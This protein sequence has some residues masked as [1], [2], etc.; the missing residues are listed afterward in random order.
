MGRPA[1]RYEAGQTLYDFAELTNSGDDTTFSA[2]FAP[3]SKVSGFEP[4]FGGYGLLTGAGITPGSSNDEVD[5]AALTVFAPGMTGAN[6]AGVVAVSAATGV[7][8]TRAVSTDT[9][10]INSITVDSTGTVVAVTGTDGT[11]FSETRGAAGG[12]PLIP[13]GSVE[14]GQV[15]TTSFT[16]AIVLSSEIF[17]VPGTHQET[18]E[19]GAPSLNYATGEVVF[20][21][22]LPSIHT[23]SVTKKVYL[24]GYAPIFATLPSAYDWVPAD[25]TYS[26]SSVDTYDGPKGAASASLGSASF[27]AIISDGITENFITQAKDKEIWVE[28][29][30]DRD[31]SYP[32]QLTQGFLGVSR[33]YPASGNKTASCTVTPASATVDQVSA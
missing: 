17:Q 19:Y 12:P 22:A 8:I 7:A 23:G 32:R 24:K 26:Q 15:R 4:I 13:V 14:L 9:H 28:F 27:T 3:V 11:S 29:R 10:M 31:Q 20:A 18:S 33:S 5:V 30:P 1:I 16:S 2:S 6:S 21:D 25:N